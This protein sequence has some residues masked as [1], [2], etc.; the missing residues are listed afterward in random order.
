MFWKRQQYICQ[1]PQK[2]AARH[3]SKHLNQ[4]SDNGDWHNHQNAEWGLK[5]R[6]VC[7]GCTQGLAKYCDSL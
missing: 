4:G 3:A 5:L 2:K 7:T 6:K 1:Q